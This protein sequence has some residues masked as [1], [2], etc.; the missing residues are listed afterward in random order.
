MFPVAL[1][2]QLEAL[3]IL[4]DVQRQLLDGA[5]VEHL[6][7]FMRASSLVRLEL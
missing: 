6:R 5:V 7:E 3:E 2:V 4:N 1:A